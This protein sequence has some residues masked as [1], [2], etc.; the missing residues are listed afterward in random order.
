MQSHHDYVLFLQFDL[1]FVD[2]YRVREFE[3]NPIVTPEG[4]SKK[5]KVSD[6]SVWNCDGEVISEPALHVK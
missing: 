2:V 5:Y 4:S 3:F 1:D 6:A